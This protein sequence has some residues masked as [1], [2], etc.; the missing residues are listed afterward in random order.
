[1]KAKGRE[2]HQRP[3]FFRPNGK[4]KGRVFDRDGKT[5]LKGKGK[6]RQHKA[7][8]AKGGDKGKNVWTLHTKACP[9]LCEH[10]SC[11]G[12]GQGCVYSHEAWRIP[13]LQ[14]AIS[15]N[16]ACHVGH[17]PEK[18]NGE[19]F[20]QTTVIQEHGL[21]VPGTLQQVPPFAGWAEDCDFDADYVSECD[22]SDTQSA[23]E[24]APHTAEPQEQQEDDEEESS[25]EDILS[26]DSMFAGEGWHM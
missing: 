1:M 15:R 6:G 8:K 21:A 25:W 13:R 10:G 2:P 11:E 24:D 19:K 23:F 20:P 16:T 18:Y 4:G 7:S 5:K 12:E 9:V 22:Y 17:W 14:R 3:P 26:D